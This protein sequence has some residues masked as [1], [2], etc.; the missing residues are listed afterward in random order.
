MPDY[1]VTQ[2]RPGYLVETTGNG[3]VLC[4]RCA[5]DRYAST[6]YLATGTY[7]PTAPTPDDLAEAYAAVTDDTILANAPERS[8]AELL[9]CRSC[10]LPIGQV[11]NNAYCSC[12]DGCE[13]G[14]CDRC[15]GD[16]CPN[17]DSERHSECAWCPSCECD[18]CE[19][20]DD[21][22]DPEYERMTYCTCENCV[23]GEE[24]VA[25]ARARGVLA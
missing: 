22:D 8:Y 13:A 24:Y 6:H 20:D 17:C 3:R 15:N 12:S 16:A 7:L 25:A 21:D 9:S 4:D 19:C 1:V 2:F 10:Y 11:V 23:A 5:S 14:A 18:P